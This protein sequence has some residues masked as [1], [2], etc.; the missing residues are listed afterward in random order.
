MANDFLAG[1]DGDLQIRN[2]DFVIGP[3]DEQHIEDYLLSAP[4]NFK[5]SPHVGIAMQRHID[6]GHNART[7]A[8]LRKKVQLQLQADGFR[9]NNIDMLLNTAN[10]ILSIAIN[11][12]R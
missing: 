1:A 10:E 11:A 5:E 7:L 4:G 6:G 3:G 9:I 8:A 2:G 12:D